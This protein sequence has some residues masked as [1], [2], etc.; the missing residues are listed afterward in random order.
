[1]ADVTAPFD[2]RAVR[3]RRDRAAA[4]ADDHSFLFD[5]V[6]ER[7]LDRLEDVNRQFPDALNLSGRTGTIAR[8]IGSRPKAGLT[9]TTDLSAAMA[10]H[11]PAPRLVA[12]EEA[13]PFAAA[14]F[15]LILSN[16]ALHWV[17]D[18][19]GA[20][21]QMRRVLK[22]DGMLLAA[23]AGGDT[24]TELRES[25]LSAE[26]EV[27]GGA[28]PRTSPFADIR[29]AGALLQRAGFAL[30]V[31]DTDTITVTYPDALA[32]MRDLRAM[33]ET[34]AVARRRKNFTR[35]ETLMAAAAGYQARY[36][37]A[38]GRIPATFQILFLT[39]WGPDDSQ[40]KPLA[41]GSA[42]ARLADALDAEEQKTGETVKPPKR[43]I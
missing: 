40:Q 20:L 26:A 9:V 35:R 4:A 30:P 15:D 19:P 42:T 7:L 13:L 38:E 8:V 25:L 34:N 1:M 12:D 41:P 22:P 11:A 23:M 36:G 43:M 6:A 14:S 3:L 17:N 39:G 5:A 31:V 32:L 2:R 24:L 21:I 16:F 33:G 28:S 29:D 37:D 27:E 10:A 18:L